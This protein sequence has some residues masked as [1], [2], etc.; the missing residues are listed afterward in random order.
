M[1]A[2]LNAIVG[3]DGEAERLVAGALALGALDANVHMDLARVYAQLDRPDEAL[4]QMALAYE[5]GYW[6]AFFPLIMPGLKPLQGDPRFVEMFAT[7]D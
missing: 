7:E 6:D 4:G 2:Q 3:H 1:R 5:K